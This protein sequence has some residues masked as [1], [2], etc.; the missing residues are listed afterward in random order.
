MSRY[1]KNTLLLLVI[2]AVIMNVFAA[3]RPA[4]LA[5]GGFFCS[6]NPIDQNAERII[7]MVNKS[8]QTITAIVGINYVGSAKDFSWVVPVPSAPKLDVAAT[9]SLNVLDSTTSVQ[10][11]DPPDYCGQL[12]P[13]LV[14]FGGGGGGGGGYL[15]T[16]QVGPYDYA[17]IYNKNATEMVDWLRNNGYRVTPEMEPII[18]QYV[19]EGMYFLAMRLHQGEDVSAIQPIVMT[20]KANHPMIP[21]RLTAV[22]AVKDMP[23]ITWIF[24]DTQYIPKNYAH[25]T[26]DFSGFTGPNEVTNIGLGY[27]SRMFYSPMG[28]YNSELKHIQE[29]YKGLAYI[30]EYAQP[31]AKLLAGS[32][33]GDTSVQGDPLLPDL[34]KKYPYVTRLRAQMSPEQMTVDP[35]FVPASGRAD[36]SNIITLGKQVGVD[37]IL[38]SGC[39]SRSALSKNLA[40]K[41]PKTHTHF[42]DWQFDV[43]HP[44]GWV[45]SQLNVNDQIVRVFAPV[46]VD[47]DTLN[48]FFAGDDTVPMFIFTEMHEWAGGGAVG[49]TEQKTNNIAKL[50]KV[51]KQ[52]PDNFVMPGSEQHTPVD[53]RYQPTLGYSQTSTFQGVLF[54]IL[55]RTSDWRANG[56]LYDAMLNY[57]KSYQYYTRPD[58]R[59]TLFLNPPD[60]SQ[61]MIL[62]IPFPEGWAE[63]T[64][65]GGDVLIMPD[66]A[67]R[68]E[69]SPSMRLTPVIPFPSNFYTSDFTDE[70][71][72][73]YRNGVIKWAIGYY[74]LTNKIDPASLSTCRDD[75]PIVTAFEKD[76]R[77][78]YVVL[79]NEFIVGVYAP[80]ANFARYKDTLVAMLDGF[81]SSYNCPG[82]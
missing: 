49:A 17:V 53:M 6:T 68:T 23:I 5:C 42:V 58:F 51:L 80:K 15:E 82:Q 10:V 67:S 64:N 32:Y 37:P 30:T 21:I 79:T 27:S 9:L 63:Q 13:N 71:Y 1:M 60:F 40:S 26:V 4:A 55:T 8:Q 46:A 2:L 34:I 31:S 20:Y 77:K 47:G 56:T 44:D 70:Y 16:G 65:T 41:V 43:A 24:G 39:S 7:F 33:D 81:R 12:F 62:Q 66:G 59:Y 28:Q 19:K 52:T 45:L 72:K 18:V 76:G 25:P 48:A 11:N 61:P 57:A 35:T 74:G 29:Q 3:P 36:V 54:G 69:S 78:G 73:N 50:L 14:E 75:T 22:A 38:Y